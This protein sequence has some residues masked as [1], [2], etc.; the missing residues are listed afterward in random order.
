[1]RIEMERTRARAF[2]ADGQARCPPREARRR[3]RYPRPV[4]T[5]SSAT[6]ER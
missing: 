5:H 2:V 4:I 3:P 1:V 6:D